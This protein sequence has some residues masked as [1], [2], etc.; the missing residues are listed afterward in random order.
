MAAAVVI[1]QASGKV[2]HETKAQAH[3]ALEGMINRPQ[4]PGAGNR[5][6]RAKLHV[7][8]CRA[9]DAAGVGEQLAELGTGDG[10]TDAG[11][12]ARRGAAGV[13]DTDEVAQLADDG[14]RQAR[15]HEVR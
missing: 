3:R 2:R 15:F 7:Y 6:G 5:N 1:C 13:E 9:C 14:R 10:R 11:Q 12:R 8:H 4:R